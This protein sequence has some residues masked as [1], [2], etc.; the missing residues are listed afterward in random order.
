MSGFCS[1]LA[2]TTHRRP[3]PHSFSGCCH[4]GSWLAKPVQNSSMLPCRGS[5]PAA[6]CRAAPV[7]PAR[8]E[9]ELDA[10]E[11]AYRVHDLYIWLS[12]RLEAA[13]PGRAAAVQ[14]RAAVGALIEEALPRLIADTAVISQRW[15][16]PL[17]VLQGC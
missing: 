9:A 13:F 2:D 11:A 12:Y 10:L 6:L 16:L 7:R 3:V 8:S 4:A 1:V 5:V 15:G 14:A 17:R